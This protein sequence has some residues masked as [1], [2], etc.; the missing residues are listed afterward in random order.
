MQCRAPRGSGQKPGPAVPAEPQV[1]GSKTERGDTGL[2]E[3]LLCRDYAI[4][5]L[6]EMKTNRGGGPGP[7]VACA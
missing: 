7:E 2:R 1:S 6:Q 4:K 3:D 5:D